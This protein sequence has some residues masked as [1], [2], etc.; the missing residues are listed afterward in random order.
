MRAIENSKPGTRT[1]A[2]LIAALSMA[3]TMPGQTRRLVE[4]GDGGTPASA[5][6]VRRNIYSPAIDQKYV[7]WRR[8]GDDESPGHRSE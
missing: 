7:D 3:V 4:D 6:F 1:L 8:Q 2:V 5:T